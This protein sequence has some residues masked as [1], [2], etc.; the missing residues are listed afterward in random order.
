MGISKPIGVVKLACGQRFSAV[1]LEIDVGNTRLKWRV[2]DVNRQQVAAGRCAHE[3]AFLDKLHQQFLDLES[4]C[5]ACVA[6]VSI[7]QDICRHVLALWKIDAQ[8][9]KTQKRHAGLHIA[10]DDPARLGVDRWLAM[11]AAWHDAK[12]AV[13]VVDCGSAITIDRVDASGRHLGGYIVPGLA[14]QAKA[15]LS[16]TGQIRIEDQVEPC[17]QAWGTSTEEAVNFGLLRM[18]TG[19]INAIVDEIAECDVAPALYISGGDAPTLLPLLHHS[20]RFS[21]RP[22]L[23]M[24]G[25][26]IALP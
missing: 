26:V 8:F 12:R 14:M 20:D 5:I 19:F 13:C 21:H 1:K 17:N 22:D 7:K 9:A 2:M 16:S 15:L 10:Y 24:D 18:V 6:Q 23:V 11:L 25:L 4:V 3:L